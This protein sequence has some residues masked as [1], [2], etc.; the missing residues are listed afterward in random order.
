MIISGRTGRPTGARAAPVI[1]SG[2]EAF[3]VSTTGSTLTRTQQA[4]VGAQQMHIAMVAPPYFSVPPAAY[5]GI[6]TV[7]ADLVDSLV[8]RGHKVTLIGAGNHATRAQRFHPTYDVGPAAQL[9]EVMPEMVHAAKVA[10]ILDALDV[11]VIHD[12]TMAG[13]LM[14]R[15]R[16]TPTVVTAHG[17]VSGDSGE[18]Y[19]ALGDTVQLVAI[20]DAQRSSAPDLCW[21]AT[22]HNAI[23]S[24]TFPFRAEKDDYAIFLGRFHPEKAPHLAIDAARAAGMPIVL[25]GKCSEPIERAYFSRE[26]EPRIGSDVTIYGVADAAAK[27]RLLS[28]AACMLFPICWEEPFGMVVIE[29]MVCGTPVVALRRGAVPELI[30]HGQTGIIVD[31]PEDLPAGIVLAL[32]LEPAVCRKHVEAGF[33]VEVMAEGY[34]AVYRQALTMAPEPWLAVQ[35]QAQIISG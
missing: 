8:A 16:L 22:V 11:D 15:G 21:A 24:E 7:V 30:V 3:A 28:R 29:A 14:A 33:T 5:G 12:H 4:P 13:P 32:Q 25:A 23:S 6:E 19:R 20:S 35:D 27:R 31:D 1:P 34:E 26:I 10:T 18:Y 9:G 17:P 2:K